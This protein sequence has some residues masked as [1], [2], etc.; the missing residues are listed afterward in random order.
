MFAHP[1]I[2]RANATSII[3]DDLVRLRGDESDDTRKD[4]LAR[5]CPDISL[6]AA[7]GFSLLVEA[8]D[9]GWVYCRLDFCKLQL[10]KYYISSLLPSL[11]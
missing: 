4:L 6:K 11:S 8:P 3:T 7:A 5:D 2:S 10:H 1:T 9:G